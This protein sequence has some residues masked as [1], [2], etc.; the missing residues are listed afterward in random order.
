MTFQQLS[1]F[2]QFCHLVNFILTWICSLV[3]KYFHSLLVHKHIWILFYFFELCVSYRSRLWSM[4]M[5]DASSSTFGLVNIFPF[6]VTLCNPYV[7][8]CK[9]MIFGSQSPHV[10]FICI[11][12]HATTLVTWHVEFSPWSWNCIHISLLLVSRSLCILIITSYIR[13]PWKRMHHVIP[14]YWREIDIFQPSCFE[15]NVS[16]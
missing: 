12:L 14:C 13:I 4:L 3:E 16:C 8:I 2:S 7:L 9:L 6:A 10:N 1:S 15:C 5:L 11:H